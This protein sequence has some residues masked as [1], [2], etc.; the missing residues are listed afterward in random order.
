[1]SKGKKRKKAKQ[2]AKRI[3]KAKNGKTVPFDLQNS[4]K[5]YAG[6]Q[7]RFCYKTNIHRLIYKDAKFS[8]IK[9]QAS[10]ITNCNYKNTK[11]D[12]IDFVGCNLKG[13]NFSGAT[14]RNVVFMCCKLKGVNF[15]NCKFHNVYFIMTN[16]EECIGFPEDG[17]VLMHSYPRLDVEEKIKVAVDRIRKRKVVNKHHILNVKNKMN[18]WYIKILLDRY[19]EKTGDLL[20]QLS[21]ET[22]LRNYYSLGSYCNHIENNYEIC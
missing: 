21:R 19:G 12:S 13:T 17:Y 6:F 4:P 10:N 14:F 16:N 22:N 20:L 8:N 11:L 1:M 18:M 2:K 7:N 15:T 3:R 5:K 9:Y